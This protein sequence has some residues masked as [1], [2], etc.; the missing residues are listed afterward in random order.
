MTAEPWPQI[1][2][3]TLADKVYAEIRSRILDAKFS[4][5]EFIREQEV[6]TGMGVSRTPVREALSRLA[7]EGFLERMPHR[8]FRVPREPLRELLDLYPIVSAL[9][10][11]AGRDSFPRLDGNDLAELRRLNAE[12]RDAMERGDSPKSIELNNQFH[13]RMCERS[14]NDRL[15]ALLDDLRSQVTRLELWYFSYREHTE[16]S[17]REHEEILAALEAKQFDLAMKVLERNW[18]HTH[19]M[20]LEEAGRS[21]DGGAGSSPD[22]PPVPASGD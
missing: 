15:S 14:G 12:L 8:G 18:L 2:A 13:H 11:L 3:V 5:G 21:S 16:L 22:G 17:V 1:P 20:L 6:S 19:T 7:S 9:E 10:V 4:P